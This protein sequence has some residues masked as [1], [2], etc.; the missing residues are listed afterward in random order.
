MAINNNINYAIINDD[1]MVAATAGNLSTSL[2]IKNYIDS[3]ST[4]LE[5]KTSA[6]AASTVAYTAT[7]ANGALG[8]GATLTNADTQAAFSADGV[9]PTVGQRVLIKNQAAPAQ[10]GIYTVTTV[11][12]GATNWVLTRATD[13]DTAA[14]IQP[15]DLVPIDAGGAVNGGTSWLQTATVVTV[16]TD[17][18][19]FIQFTAALPIPLNSGGTGANL[20]ASNGGIFYSTASAGAILAGTATANQ[21]L[22]SGSNSA[23][24]WS[25]TTYPATNAINTIMYASSANILGVIAAANS[26]VLITGAT[27]V[28]AMSGAMTNGQLIVGSTG[29]IPVRATLTAGVGISIT[30]GAGTITVAGT[31][32]GLGWTEVTGTTQAMAVDSGYIASNGSQVVLTLPSTAALGTIVSVVGKGAGGW[33]IHQNASQ[34]IQVGSSSTTAGVGGTLTSTNRFDSIQLVCTT[35]NLTWTA[36]G[37]PQSAGLTIV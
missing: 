29:A 10:N 21:L 26:S 15:G 8:V 23:P 14:E 34:N 18:V 30:N 25:T 13:Y 28:P 16:G 12:S 4:G 35:A 7:Y 1:T 20:T 37:G 22:M 2:A 31:G 32:G 11:G 36:L 6:V 33:S 27:G 24:S 5:I 17:P 19:T 3:V 9:S